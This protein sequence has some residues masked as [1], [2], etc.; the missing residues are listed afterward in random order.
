MGCLYGFL[1]FT[2]FGT[3]KDFEGWRLSTQDLRAQVS[4]PKGKQQQ[5]QQR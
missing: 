4:P 3:N 5:K 2:R 1:G